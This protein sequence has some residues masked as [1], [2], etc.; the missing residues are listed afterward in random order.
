MSMSIRRGTLTA[1]VGLTAAAMLLMAGARPAVALPAPASPATI[2]E[3]VIVA[4]IVRSGS[5]PE[6][7]A[8]RCWWP[9]VTRSYPNRVRVRTTAITTT[10]PVGPTARSRCR[11][12]GSGVAARSAWAEP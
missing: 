5:T 8:A 11:R 2:P 6:K 3:R 1:G 10:V 12:T 7:A 4:T 9:L